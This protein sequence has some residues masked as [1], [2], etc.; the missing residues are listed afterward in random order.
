MALMR[1]QIDLLTKHIVASSENVNVVGPPNRYKDQDIDLDEEVKHLGNQRGFQNYNSGHQ[2]YNSGNAGNRDRVSRSSSRS[3]LEDMLAKVLQKDESTDAGVKEMKGDLSSTENEQVMEKTG[4]EETEAEHV[5]DSQDAQPIAKQTGA[6]E[7]GVEGIMPLQ[8]ISRPP[9]PFPQSHKKKAEDGKFV[10]FITMLRK[11]S[12]NIP[13]V[14]ALE[15]MPRYA[16]FMKDLV[17]KKRVLSIDFTD[18]VHHC[19]AIATRSLVKRV[20]DPGAFTIPCTI[21]LIEFAKALCDLGANINLIPLAIYKQLGLGVPKPTAMRL[22][23]ADRSAKRPMGILCDVLIKVDTF[24]FQA[25]FVILDCEV[26]FEVP[27]ILGRPF[28]ATG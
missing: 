7:K 26:D 2:G 23:M 5:Y 24:I 14:D 15:H 12:V 10:K 3:K 13:L 28:I 20:E 16:K 8:Q 4:R 18:N 11:L 19:S 1:T 22:M 17:T 9:P 21:G 6:T 25:D 27:I